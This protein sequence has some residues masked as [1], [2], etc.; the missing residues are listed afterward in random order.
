MYKMKNL[1]SNLLFLGLVLSLT[2]GCT[3]YT[4]LFKPPAILDPVPV[5]ESTRV[6]TKKD[7]E[8]TSWGLET[9]GMTQEYLADA[10]SP[11]GSILVKVAILS[12]GVDYNNDD[13]IGQVDVNKNEIT[14]AS[15]IEPSFNFKDD[16]EDGEVDNIV[17]KDLVDG[18]GLAFDRHGAGTAVAGIIAA[19]ANGFG[20]RGIVDKVSLVPVR[21][22]NDNGQS[23]IPKLAQALDYAYSIQPDVVFVQSIDLPS[24]GG[25]VVDPSVIEIEKGLIARSLKRFA[26]TNIPIVVGAGETMG[27]FDAS[28]LGEIFAKSPNVIAVTSTDKNGN[29]SLLAN[30]GEKTVKLAAPGDKIIT[31]GLNNTTVEVRGTAFAAAHVAGALALAKAKFGNGLNLKDHVMPA[32][33]NPANGSE[34]ASVEWLVV[35]GS[36]LNIPK[37]LSGIEANM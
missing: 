31:A 13:L 17:G 9:V 35:S 27:E 6:K 37:L 23:D 30:R 33:A 4:I 25:Y 5:T 22:I 14:E 18:D 8:A 1:K 34:S 36:I 19:K 15:N 26:G 21:Y 20:T 2:V 12:T 10:N 11:K 3:Q 7:V 16:D 29:L 24:G 28:P 32:V